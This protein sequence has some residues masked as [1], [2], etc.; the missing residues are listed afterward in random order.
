MIDAGEDVVGELSLRTLLMLITTII[1]TL[2][3]SGRRDALLRAVESVHQASVHPVRILIIVNGQRFD[4]DLVDLLQSRKDVEVI[5]I[6]EG[7]LTKAHLAGRQNIS[8]EYFSF[9]DDDDE[10]LAGALDTR[11]ALMCNN[12]AA[13]VVV[14]NG[15]SNQAGNDRLTY[16]RFANISA[17]PLYE[18]FQENWLH[19]C[20]HLFRS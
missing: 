5:Q 14:T 4:P 16:S 3:E 19:S 20:N 8:T 12:C 13:D 17:N 2:C 18:L 15:Y 7:S 10:Y 1:P 6:A 9:L 11:L